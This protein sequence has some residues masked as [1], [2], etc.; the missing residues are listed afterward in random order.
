MDFLWL[1]DERRDS[2]IGLPPRNG[3]EGDKARRYLSLG[4]RHKTDD[5]SPKISSFRVNDFPG[6][7]RSAGT[8][9]PRSG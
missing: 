9:R 3:D 6:Q 5:G 7:I 4:S 2:H 1:W 8:E